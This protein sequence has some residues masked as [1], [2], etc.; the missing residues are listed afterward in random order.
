M[1]GSNPSDRFPFPFRDIH[2]RVF[3]GTASDRYAGW[4]G[5]IYSEER[6]ASRLTRRTKQVG[7][8]R[9]E[10][11][12]LPVSSVAEYFRHFRTLELDFTFYRPLLDKGGDPTQTYYLLQKYTRYLNAGDRLILK[13]PQAVFAQKLHGQKGYANNPDYLNADFFKERFYLPALSLLDPWIDG[14]IFEQEYQRVK[15]RLS[16][17]EQS[18]ALDRFFKKLPEDNRYH[19]ELRTQGFLVRPIFKVLE[20]HGI[21]QVL[22]HWTWL[23]TLRKQFSLS[24]KQFLKR[25]Q[26]CV[27]RLMTPRGMR[28]EVA[29]AKA[30][31]FDNLIDGM[32]T[33]GMVT[34]TANIMKAAVES[35]VDISVIVNNRSGGNAPLVAAEVARQFANALSGQSSRNLGG[36]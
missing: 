16:I 17:E 15:D 18:V 28:Y 19:V 31:P 32:M 8:K 2:P 5:Q 10:E 1:A 13:V 11:V 21:G 29:Y 22:S 24:G 6:Y 30:H 26:K 7:G 36:S 14:F 12:V 34:D 9:F 33:A 35:E 23:P 25:G 4:I 3:M 27:I 20:T